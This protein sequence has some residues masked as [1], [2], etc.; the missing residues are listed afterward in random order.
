MEWVRPDFEEIPVACEIN[1]YAEATL[2]FRLVHIKDTWTGRPRR[3][4]TV[5][6]CLPR[7]AVS[8]VREK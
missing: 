7:I 5:E 6:L 3:I 1:S 4:S 2:E 8:C